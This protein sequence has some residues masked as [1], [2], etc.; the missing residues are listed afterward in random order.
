MDQQ[1]LLRARDDFRS[2][3]A[4]LIFHLLIAARL[5]IFTPLM[6]G[7]SRIVLARQPVINNYDIARFVL[8]PARPGSWS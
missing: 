6:A 8:S 5:A 3:G 7:C 1:L 2:D 4:S